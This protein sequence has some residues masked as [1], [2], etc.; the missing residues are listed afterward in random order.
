MIVAGEIDIAVLGIKNVARGH[1]QRHRI[2]R[3]H[4]GMRSK[5]DIGPSRC[6]TSVNTGS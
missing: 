5:I 2:D 3:D 4:L 1:R 6:A